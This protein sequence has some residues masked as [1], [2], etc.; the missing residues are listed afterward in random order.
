VAQMPPWA[1]VVVSGGVTLPTALVGLVRY[2]MRLAFLRYVY[3]RRGDR[4]DLE[5]AGRALAS[6]WPTLGRNGQP[7]PSTPIDAPPAP[8]RSAPGPDNESS[9]VI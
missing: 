2:R 8:L 3:D 1:W 9:L 7:A 6:V 4:L 5:A